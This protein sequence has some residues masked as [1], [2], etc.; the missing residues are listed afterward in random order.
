VISESTRRALTGRWSISRDPYL[1][2]APTT[3]ASVVLIEA[4]TYTPSEIFGWFLASAIGYLA[5]CVALYLAHRT[6]LR[7]RATVP[8]PVWWIFVL[9]FTAGVLKGLTTALVS[10]IYGVDVDLMAAIAI[11]FFAA[12]MLGL[13]GVPTLAIV[14]NS[15]QEFR[16]KRAKLIAEQVLVESRELQSQEVIAAMSD[17]LRNLYRK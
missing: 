2:V 14:M 15:L 11:R 1:F 5:F 3:I 6:I 13:I 17:Q 12:G 4:T 7:H 10:Y 8:T 9:G 16:E